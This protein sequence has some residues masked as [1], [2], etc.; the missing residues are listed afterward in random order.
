MSTEFETDMIDRMARVETLLTEMKE[1]HTK[2]LDRHYEVS[3]RSLF[4]LIGAGISLIISL[5]K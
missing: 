2:H 1:S 4:A 3:V 5:F